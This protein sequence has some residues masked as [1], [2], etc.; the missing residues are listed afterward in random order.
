MLAPSPPFPFV[1]D[2]HGDDITA[3]DE[4][5]IFLALE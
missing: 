1:I 2:Y 4:E 3:E 5:G